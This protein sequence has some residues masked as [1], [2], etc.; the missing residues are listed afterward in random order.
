MMS[1]IQLLFLELLCEVVL[2]FLPSEHQHRQTMVVNGPGWPRA[3]FTCK[4]ARFSVG[5]RFSEHND[6][7]VVSVNPHLKDM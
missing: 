7:K 5:S 3:F 4:M 1:T 2:A 6:P